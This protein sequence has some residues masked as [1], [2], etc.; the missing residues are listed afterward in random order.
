MYTRFRIASSEDGRSWRIIADLSREARDRPNAYIE[1]PAPVR[2]RFVRYLHGHVGAATLAISD[3]R[4]FGNAGGAR[5]AAPAGLTV[6][7]DTDARDAHID[8][9]SVPHVVGYNIRWGVAAGK[10]H[11][12]YQIFADEGAS[13][14][15]RA[16]TI[17]QPYYFAIESF[18]ENGVSQLSETVAIK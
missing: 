18:D 17:G 4:I 9:T 15:V 16:L 12:T 10:L 14:D 13:L 2:A 7:R 1:L 8:W 11:E 6:V 5:P 3:V